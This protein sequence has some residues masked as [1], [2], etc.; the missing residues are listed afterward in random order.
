MKT[1]CVD[2][3]GVLAQYD[4]WKGHEHIGEPISGAVR[5]TRALGD[6]CH[7]TIHTSRSE[8]HFVETWLK[9]HAFHFSSIWQAPGKPMAVAYVDD[10]AVLCRPEKD[11]ENYDYDRALRMCRAL[12]DGDEL[13]SQGT[14]S[15]GKLNDD[16][17]GDIKMM[18]SR[19]DGV[20]RVDFGKPVGWL[21]LPRAE[22][23]EF[24]N[25]ILKHAREL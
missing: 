1:V 10:R 19:A 2:L 16:D 21:G 14:F 4:G 22:A 6:F 25:L 17:E 18:I 3:D 8:L 5:F 13:G 20:V 15:K 12:C 7:V 9:K 24:A 11:I 23:E